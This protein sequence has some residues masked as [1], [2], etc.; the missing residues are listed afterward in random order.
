MKTAIAKEDSIFE[1][2]ERQMP[3]RTRQQSTSRREDIV[4]HQEWEDLL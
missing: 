4:P 2:K 1:T 3:T